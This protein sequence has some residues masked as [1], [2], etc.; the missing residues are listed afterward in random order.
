MDLRRA[1]LGLLVSLDALLA[2]RSVTA[3]ARRLGIS[4]PALSA[5]L[6]RLRDLFGDDLLVGNAHGMTL[7]PRAAAL[8]QPLHETLGELRALVSAGASFDPATDERTFRIAAADLA[9]AVLLPRLLPALGRVAPKLRLACVPL[10]D[11]LKERMERGEADFAAT[12]ASNALEGLPARKLLRDDYVAIWR[13]GHPR[14]GRTLTLEDFCAVD[15][16]IV[17]LEGGDLRSPLDDMLRERGLARRVAASVPNFLLV[18]SAVRASDFLS[19]APSS[20]FALDGAGLRA[21]SPPLPLPDITLY[22]SW[23]PRT[24]NDPAHRWMRR[25]IADQVR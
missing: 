7:T 10:V 16:L 24:R 25:F 2:E 9:L 6:A 1:D 23:H 11:D 20:L 19:V 13:E 17:D 14:L 8:R 3:A 21:A 12:G 15:H 22:L 18:P 5:Q 4:Q